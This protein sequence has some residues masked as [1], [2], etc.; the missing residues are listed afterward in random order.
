MYICLNMYIHACNVFICMCTYVY[1]YVCG[2]IS[3]EQYIFKNVI[4]KV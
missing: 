1:V 3:Q 2:D 4:I